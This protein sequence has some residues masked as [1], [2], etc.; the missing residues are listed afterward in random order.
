MPAL[1]AHRYFFALLPD[2]ISRARIHAWAERKLGPEGIQGPDRLHLTLAITPDFAAPQPR[3]ADAL[4]RAGERAN[5]TSFDLLLDKLSIG[6][7]SVA[8]RPA[9]IQL[10]LRSLQARIV[11]AM[12]A[13]GGNIRSGWTFSPHLTLAYRTSRPSTQPVKDR[14]WRVH[15]FVL[16][17]SLVGLT[18]HELLGRWPLGENPVVQLSLF[19]A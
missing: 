2:P 18:R 14:G 17:H 15:E 5:G 4:A 13:N 6:A 11:R 9:H 3:L 10:P 12:H 16:I 19:P 7:R 8:V 1:L